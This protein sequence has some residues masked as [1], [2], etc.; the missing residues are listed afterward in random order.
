VRRQ[1]ALAV[2]GVIACGLIVGLAVLAPGCG[3]SPLE[4]FADRLR[5]LDQQVAQQKAQLAATLRT[6]RLRNG[7][8]ARLLKQQIQ[9]LALTEGRIARL[10]GP[11]EVKRPLAQYAKASAA[12]ITVL[13]RFA[14]AIEA[15]DQAGVNALGQQT[16]SSEGAVRRADDGLHAT[17][18]SR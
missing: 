8:D 3:K 7:A 18:N 5:P 2:R 16:Q 15:G 11:D 1:H 17:L 13:N 14:S 9:A 12:Q 4:K 6:A 10:G